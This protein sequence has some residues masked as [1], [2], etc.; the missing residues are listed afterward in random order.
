MRDAFFH[1]DCNRSQLYSGILDYTFFRIGET[2]HEDDSKLIA[3]LKFHPGDQS[4]TI[5]LQVERRLHILQLLLT[6][7]TKKLCTR[8]KKFDKD[9][10]KFEEILKTTGK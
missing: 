1:D 6:N 3:F 10:F 5:Y 2:I 8:H 4:E 9:L 7:V